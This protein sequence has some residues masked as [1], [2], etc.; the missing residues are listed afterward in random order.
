MIDLMILRAPKPALLLGQAYDYFD[1]RGLTRAY[2]DMRHFYRILDRP[3]NVKLFIGTHGH[4]YHR[5]NQ[6]AMV[7]FF[8]R[9]AGIRKVVILE[10][11]IPIHVLPAKVSK[12]MRFLT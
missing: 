8:A 4:G 7:K 9:H 12:R 6:E 2:W 11:L 5:E 3:G 10:K 1:R